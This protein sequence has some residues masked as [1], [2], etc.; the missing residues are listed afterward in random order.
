MLVSADVPRECVRRGVVGIRDGTGSELDV[1]IGRSE[2]PVDRWVMYD[3]GGAGGG[4]MLRGFLVRFRELERDMDVGW[5]LRSFASSS[6][7]PLPSS[8]SSSLASLITTTSRFKA[9]LPSWINMDNLSPIQSICQIPLDV[10]SNVV[11]ER[12]SNTYMIIHTTTR[13]RVLLVSKVEF[14]L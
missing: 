9:F 3:G 10:R 14:R 6:H 5:G 7:A 13:F 1:G 4:T 2:V 8:T 11:R 12:G